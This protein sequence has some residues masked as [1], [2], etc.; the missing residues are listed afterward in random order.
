MLNLF[1]QTQFVG[2]FELNIDADSVHQIL[3][4]DYSWY[5]HK[6]PSKYN[7]FS[8]FLLLSNWTYLGFISIKTR[9]KKQFLSLKAHNSYIVTQKILNYSLF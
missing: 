2:F 1:A 5:D 3:L 6:K 4:T 7:I 9:N 8:W